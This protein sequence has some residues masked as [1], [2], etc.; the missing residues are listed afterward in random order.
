MVYFE[1]LNKTKE[2]K[3]VYFYKT[4]SFYFKVTINILQKERLRKYVIIY[5][6]PI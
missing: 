1:T 6:V 5:C 3:M 4:V 2:F